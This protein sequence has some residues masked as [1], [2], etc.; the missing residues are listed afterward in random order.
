VSAHYPLTAFS[1][2]EWQSEERDRYLAELQRDVDEAQA[3]LTQL[4][5]QR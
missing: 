1:D 3:R 2:A 4:E 5:A